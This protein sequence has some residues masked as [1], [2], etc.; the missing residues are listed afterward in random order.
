MIDEFIF[1][2]TMPCRAC[3]TLH[4]HKTCPRWSIEGCVVLRD[5]WQGVLT[6]SHPLGLVSVFG[7]H[8]I[9][10]VPEVTMRTVQLTC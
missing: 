3:L 4:A 1:L 6:A 8:E 10:M 2:H 9:P 7:L 5:I